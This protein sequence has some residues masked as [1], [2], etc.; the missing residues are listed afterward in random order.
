MS[1]DLNA[2]RESLTDW[3]KTLTIICEKA[4][5]FLTEMPSEEIS[6]ALDEVVH[7]YENGISDQSPTVAM[8]I[9]ILNLRSIFQ[10]TQSPIEK[11]FLNALNI[12]AFPYNEVCIFFT[13]QVN[14]IGEAVFRESTEIQRE[15]LEIWERFRKIEEKSSAR[16]FIDFLKQMDFLTEGQRMRIFW[17]VFN[18]YLSKV[19]GIFYVTLQP[20]IKDILSNNR[21]IRPDIYIWHPHYPEFKL[22]VECD[23]YT[24]H[25]DKA[26]FSNDRARDRLLHMNG[27]K[28]LRFSGHDILSHP[29]E[30]AKEL[31][32]YLID[33]KR[34]MKSI[35]LK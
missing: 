9:G 18:E 1:I 15:M 8:N 20:P 10:Y 23:G 12:L 29:T 28:V 6:D 17:Y 16:E 22:I 32:Q 26:S 7:F 33:Q 27:Y 3:D 13:A 25:G 31:Y 34:H 11:I 5:T 21:I 30:M 35:Y 2:R 24:Y 19:Y 4:I 14:H